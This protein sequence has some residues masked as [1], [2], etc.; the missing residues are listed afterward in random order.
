MIVA[1]PRSGSQVELDDGEHPVRCL[2]CGMV[3]REG[4]GETAFHYCCKRPAVLSEQTV[5]ED[6][7]PM[8]ARFPG[9]EV[10]E[11]LGQGGSGI[12][13]LAWSQDS[14]RLVA[15]K[16]LAAGQWASPRQRLRFQREVATVAALD[17]PGV[18]PILDVGTT[19][20]G[21]PWYAMGYVLGPSLADL[22]QARGP[23]PPREVARVLRELAL[24]VQAVHDQDLVHRDIKP[25]NVLLD[26][27]G[28]PFL[29]DFG[30][31]LD[32]RDTERLTRS[33][34]VLG[35]PRYLAPEQL[36]GEVD[37]WRRLD[38]HGLGLIL[39]EALTGRLPRGP[40]GRRS[41]LSSS[42]AGEPPDLLWV[43]KRAA[44]PLPER[45]Y[46][47]ASAMARD[48]DTWLEGGRVVPISYALRQRLPGWVGSGRSLL[49]VGVLLG[50]AGL[51]SAR[52]F[53]AG[54]S[55]QAREARA[56]QLLD[57]ARVEM[58]QLLTADQG[59]E[60]AA[61]FEAFAANPAATRTRVLE[62]AWLAQGKRALQLE[63]VGA[64]TH[65]YGMAL[66]VALDED[67]RT[68]AVLGLADVFRA[69]GDRAR[70]ATLL[71]LLP[72]L[73]PEAAERLPPEDWT[74]RAMV[75]GDLAAARATAS[76]YQAK[77][78]D[79]IGHAEPQDVIRVGGWD[80]DGDGIDELFCAPTS[81]PDARCDAVLP[82]G[83]WVFP[84]GEQGYAVDDHQG[85]SRL[86]RLDE[87]TITDLEFW[88]GKFAFAL[89][90]V[91][92]RLYAAV[93]G[94]ERGLF[95]LGPD[96][97][98]P[99]HPW[100]HRLESYANDLMAGD[101]D[102]DGRPELAACFGSPYDFGVRV[103]RPAEDGTLDLIA[104]R[105]WLRASGLIVVRSPRGP[106]L[107]MS[108]TQQIRSLRVFSEEDNLAAVG[109]LEVMALEGSEL[110]VEQS[111]QL[112]SSQDSPEQN[113]MNVTACDLDGDG[114]DELVALVMPSSDSSDERRTV[115]LGWQEDGSLGDPLFIGQWEPKQCLELDG[116]PGGEL[117][118][119]HSASNGRASQTVLGLGDQP[120]A[121][122]AQLHQ[123]GADSAAQ[124]LRSLGLFV[125]AAHSL[126]LE[127]DAARSADTLLAAA[128]LHQQ[129]GLR[130]RALDEANRALR[131]FPDDA[132]LAAELILELALAQED[133]QPSLA[134]L[135]GNPALVASL[136]PR[137]AVWLEAMATPGV[138]LRFDTPLHA[139]WQQTWP[140]AVMH[141]LRTGTLRVRAPR[142]MGTLLRI[143][144]SRVEGAAWLRLEGT[145]DRAEYDSSLRVSLRPVGD[146]PE[147]ERGWARELRTSGGGGY[148]FRHLF[149]FGCE[150]RD[151]G[152]VE[153]GASLAFVESVLMLPDGDRRCTM[154][155][156]APAQSSS[157]VRAIP[158]PEAENWEL[159]V[160]AGGANGDNAGRI[161]ELVL[162]SI[163][164]GGFEV[165]STGEAAAP[166][167]WRRWA[168]GEGP[169]PKRGL[170][171][172]D[173]PEL[174]GLVRL[175]PQLM[176]RVEAELG[177]RV[178]RELTARLWEANAHMSP[179]EPRVA[180][181]LVGLR[182]PWGDDE[183]W[184]TILVGR[185]RALAAAGS[186]DEAVVTLQAAVDVAADCGSPAWLSAFRAQASLADVHLARGEESQALEHMGAA[187]EVALEPELGLR[188]LRYWP[189]LAGYESNALR[190][191]LVA[192][193]EGG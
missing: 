111:L 13:Y 36:L 68:S 18:V 122:G 124:R 184:A 145:W 173:E 46:A 123:G 156:S 136:E 49:V 43:A 63:D 77:L 176:G 34:Q 48:L 132:P 181:A 81:T 61:I 52:S 19:V 117:L 131:E 41:V 80:R 20:D 142:G 167:P 8:L 113:W 40:D 2:P 65:A 29:T 147:A 94:R 109:R 127:T 110:R 108:T 141:D 37:D 106:R 186:L 92:G 139:A 78:L 66:A 151:A 39:H 128:R 140:Q 11:V 28:H 170:A 96:G 192:E 189:Q 57:S 30:L 67:T 174:A 62:R 31:V 60:A 98:V 59:D 130:S 138:D 153:I 129:A 191:R 5:D 26:A 22:I 155:L 100:T 149:G 160:E 74:T 190:E 12:V 7:A 69:S 103:Y 23:W 164:L 159:V 64:A 101:L 97:P 188:M 84:A 180:A 114:L 71:D 137:E 168:E 157:S 183:R 120:L 54:R 185:G 162:Q 146:A 175:E 45:R 95:V 9:Y 150:W 79:M 56:Q 163:Q 133:P 15:L 21:T 3:L 112:P 116:D 1:C 144:L 38:I 42:T 27:Q 177:P 72:Q 51:Q 44:D 33:T 105:R 16:V 161:S 82:K 179:L 70:L 24:V 55:Q 158:W 119:H 87:E 125:E 50:L 35:T 75:R 6:H 86:K 104:Q 165:D 107:V 171:A 14:E 182:E 10:Q 121:I 193:I 58:A 126:E 187:V 73:A 102:G 169:A 90:E 115:L 4:S 118:L 154:Q 25:S 91:G 53:S 134:A 93:T 47:S 88:P 32:D 152:A 17:I 135:A 85:G 99:A 166:S 178:V 143:P 76:D 89:E 172:A 83:F 148:H